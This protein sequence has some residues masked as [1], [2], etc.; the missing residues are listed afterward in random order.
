MF[1]NEGWKPRP[2][3]PRTDVVVQDPLWPQ[4]YAMYREQ[5][6]YRGPR[7]PHP[8]W[9][10]ISRP[11]QIAIQQAITGAKPPAAGD[12][13]SRGQDQADPGQDAALTGLDRHRARPRWRV[14]RTVSRGRGDAA[15]VSCCC[16]SSCGAD[17]LPAG[18][19]RLPDRLQPGHERPG[20]AR[21]ATSLDLVRPFIGLDNYR[22]AVADP[23]VPKVLVNSL[24]FVG[25][26]VSGRS[27]S[28]SRR[29]C[30]SRSASP[31]A[32]FLRGL[33]LVVVDS[34]G[35]GGRCAV[36]MDVRHR[37]RR[38]QLRAAWRCI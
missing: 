25:V 24:V 18:V 13:G 29:R 36:E 15:S 23:V 30:S 31:G 2:M 37:I 6:E 33:L 20:R 35:A 3:A 12:E 38:G 27:A 34:A 10:D 7:G 5:M 26:N 1:F 8:Q 9:P 17:G 21:S 11:M 16:A 4:A 32:H 22:E 19:H 14:P 28:A